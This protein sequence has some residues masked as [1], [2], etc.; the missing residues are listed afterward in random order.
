M[1]AHRVPP[2]NNPPTADFLKIIA[3]F[4]IRDTKP[5]INK[6]NGDRLSLVNLLAVGGE[7]GRCRG[8]KERERC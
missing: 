1:M 8:R 2:N 6:H 4:G 5:R 7:D 3:I